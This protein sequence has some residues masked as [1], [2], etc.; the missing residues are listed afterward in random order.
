MDEDIEI[1]AFEDCQWRELP[2]VMYNQAEAEEYAKDHQ[3][4]VIVRT[5]R[6]VS[7]RYGEDFTDT[8]LPEDE[9]DDD[10]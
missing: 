8:D 1:F 2:F 9:S 7:S 3:C 10:W 5:Y 4:K 6:Y